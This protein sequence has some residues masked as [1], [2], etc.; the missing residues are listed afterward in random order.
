MAADRR[1]MRTFHK[2]TT[3]CNVV[4]RE[5]ANMCTVGWPRNGQ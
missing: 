5:N 3:A 4:L 2:L 1:A